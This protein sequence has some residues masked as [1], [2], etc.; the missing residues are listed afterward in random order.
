M[1]QEV[2][3]QGAYQTITIMIIIIIITML[4]VIITMIMV[5]RRLHVKKLMN[6]NF[7]SRLSTRDS[8]R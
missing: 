8:Y 3:R 4:I 5:L 7:N 6:D 2:A 1:A